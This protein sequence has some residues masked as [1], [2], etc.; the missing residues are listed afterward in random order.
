MLRTPLV[1]ADWKLLKDTHCHY[2]QEYCFQCPWLSEIELDIKQ[3]YNK[4]HCNMAPFSRTTLL[5]TRLSELV[6]A[7]TSFALYIVILNKVFERYFT[8][9]KRGLTALPAG[10]LALSILWNSVS[11]ILLIA[12]VK[13]PR[14]VYFV[15][16][17]VVAAVLVGLGTVGFVHDDQIYFRTGIWTDNSGGD[18]WWLDMEIAAVCLLYIA[19]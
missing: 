6:I 4:S 10:A 12:R 19:A 17:L 14:Y 7:I 1:V 9:D 2:H 5:I 13:S 18:E 3:A 8:S 15:G 11:T 16:D